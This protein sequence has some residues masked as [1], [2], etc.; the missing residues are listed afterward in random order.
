MRRVA[1]SIT[2]VADEIWRRS[3]QMK[4]LGEGMPP[5]QIFELFDGRLSLRDLSGDECWVPLGKSESGTKLIRCQP[6]ERSPQPLEVPIDQAVYADD[7][8]NLETGALDPCPLGERRVDDPWNHLHRQRLGDRRCRHSTSTV[9]PANQRSVRDSVTG[10]A[11]MADGD[12]TFQMLPAL[13]LVEVG[14]GYREIATGPRLQHYLDCFWVRETQRRDLHPRVVPDGCIDI[15]WLGDDNIVVAGPTTR[16]ITAETRPHST[17]VGARF[18]PGVAPSLLGVSADQIL[19]LQVPLERIW[20]RDARELRERADTQPS[21]GARLHL[22]HV[23]VASKLTDARPADAVVRAGIS[24]LNRGVSPSVR[25]LSDALSLSERQ[26]LRRFTV[27]VG[28]GPKTLDRILRLQRALDSL[29]SP[30]PPLR[31][32]DVAMRSGYADQ[33]HMTREFV[34]LTGLPPARLLKYAAR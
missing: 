2:Q 23:L 28:Y 16:A 29:R 24:S 14:P 4:W 9:A 22:L 18:Q 20:P 15:V 11:P 12:Y 27:A 33:A 30:T 19:D 7:L 6:V 17:I 34:H 25:E 13:G 8:P 21:V 10:Q 32:V 3:T 31:L 1:G 26:L 5:P